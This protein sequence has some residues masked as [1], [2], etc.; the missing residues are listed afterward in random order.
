MAD[1]LFDYGLDVWGGWTTDTIQWLC[2][3]GSGYTPNKAHNFVS[4]LT[5][6]SNEVGGG[7]GYARVTAGGKSRTVNTTTHRIIYDCNDPAFGSITAGQ[8][9]TGLVVYKF[10]T[11]DAASILL[12]YFDIADTVTTGAAFTPTLSAS[13]VHYIDQA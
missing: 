10:I 2:L 9:I 13:G 11:N 8:N 4:D 5:P 7:L 1:I 6:A 12:A 3:K